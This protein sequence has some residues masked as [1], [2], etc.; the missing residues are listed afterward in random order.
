MTVIYD[1]RLDRA[2]DKAVESSKGAVTR[3]IRYTMPS[4]IPFSPNPPI[5]YTHNKHAICRLTIQLIQVK[6]GA[7]PARERER[8]RCPNC[9]ILYMG[10]MHPTVYPTDTYC[11]Y[12]E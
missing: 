12:G 3:S 4:A 11:I 9:H 6:G 7:R 8:A 10:F 2:A 1:R 5:G